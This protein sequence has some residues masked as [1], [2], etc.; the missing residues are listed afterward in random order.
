MI[1]VRQAIE[2]L[3]KCNLDALIRIAIPENDYSENVDFIEEIDQL[4][5]HFCNDKPENEPNLEDYLNNESDFWVET[6]S[7][8]DN[9]A[10]K[11]THGVTPNLDNE[12]H[13]T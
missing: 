2:L 8:S 10:K 13:P 3:Q 4:E 9:F 1:T 5:V 11:K 6:V 12:G 7:E